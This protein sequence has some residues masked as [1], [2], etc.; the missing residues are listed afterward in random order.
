MSA[1]SSAVV[2][3][4][5]YSVSVQDKFKQI[6]CSIAFGNGTDTYPVNGI[7]LTVGQFGFRNT[8]RNILFNDP[9]SATGYV[10]KF[11]ST[12]NT[13]RIYQGNYSLPSAGPLVELGS[14]AVAATTVT[15]EAEGY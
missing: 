5:Q 7:P 6:A 4:N 11:D 2:T 3:A 8:I 9:S 13:I 1:I 15:V 14:V 12:H 10:Y